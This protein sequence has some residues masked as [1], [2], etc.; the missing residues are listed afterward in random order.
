MSGPDGALFSTT[1]YDANDSMFPLAFGVMRSDNY[2][3]WLWFLQN[4]K[5]VV[6]DKKVV[7]ISYKHPG[8]LRSVSEIFGSENHAYCYRQLKEKENF[9]SF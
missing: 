7:I 8:L 3:D 6:G 9:I 5:K 1:T 4:V 2:D